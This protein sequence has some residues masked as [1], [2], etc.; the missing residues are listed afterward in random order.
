MAKSFS[1]VFFD[2]DG[3]LGDTD[4]D[5]RRAWK[6]AIF[7]LG[8]ICPDFDRVFRVGPSLPDTAK[9]LFHDLDEEKRLLLQNT[10]KHFYDDAQEYSALPYPGIIDVLTRLHASGA[11]F[12]VVTNKR[13]KPT[14]KLMNKFQ[15]TQICS[16]MFTPDIISTDIHLSKSDLL[17]L[18]LKIS[19]AEPQKSLMVGDTEL[20]IEA[21]KN[22][23]LKTCAVSWGYGRPEVVAGSGAD[24][25][26]DSAGELLSLLC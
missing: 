14:L 22:N 2:F 5:I 13:I 24:F 9:M 3:T 11:K 26:I 7:E 23:N 16:G 12:Y 17:E 15:I 10:Y 4:P 6:N 25:F 20:D 8:L 21:G 18:A 1:A 19:G